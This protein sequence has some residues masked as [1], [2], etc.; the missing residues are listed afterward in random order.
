MARLHFSLWDAPDL[1]LLVAV[2]KRLDQALATTQIEPRRS[3][4]R[5]TCA[6]RGEA[7]RQSGR[8]DWLTAQLARAFAAQARQALPSSESRGTIP[9]KP[10][11]DHRISNTG[12]ALEANQELQPRIR[13]GSI[14]A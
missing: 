8:P 9:A 7:R 11:P 12:R 14:A 4:V 5:F 2:P 10:Q 13:K 1:P 3:A 6:F